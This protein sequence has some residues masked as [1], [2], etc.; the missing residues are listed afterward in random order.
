MPA[1]G[2][3]A[4]KGTRQ[5]YFRE[6]GGFEHCPVYDRYLL[7]QGIA[8]EGPAVIEETD[9]TTIVQPGYQAEVD[10]H[11]ILHIEEL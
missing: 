5:V 9:S 4:M 3:A 10:Q 2:R 1:S 8:I 6:T 7:G 11:G